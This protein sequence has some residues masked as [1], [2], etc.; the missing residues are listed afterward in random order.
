MIFLKKFLITEPTT[1]FVDVLDFWAFAL[2]WALREILQ[3]RKHVPYV[4]LWCPT[5]MIFVPIYF[6]MP[7]SL[8][9]PL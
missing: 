7:P 1:L 4:L 8:N 9:N 5:H 2:T 3:N 6:P